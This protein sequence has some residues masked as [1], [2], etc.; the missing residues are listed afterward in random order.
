[1]LHIACSVIIVAIFLRCACSKDNSN[2]VSPWVWKYCD[3]EG[4]E[5]YCRLP[6]TFI[7]DQLH[8]DSI[9]ELLLESGIKKTAIDQAFQL[10]YNDEIDAELD[11]NDSV[12]R[13]ASTIY[14]HFHSRYVITPDGLESVLEKYK[15]HEFGQCPRVYCQGHPVLP[16]GL[17]DTIGSVSVKMFCPCCEEVYHASLPRHRNV[18]G[19]AFGTTLPH[20]LTFLYPEVFMR[21]KPPQSYAPK[22]FGFQFRRPSQHKND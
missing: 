5:L 18:V 19:G 13:L 16:V 3:R 12:N 11:A 10:L 7:C 6:T 1:M 4:H 20:L 22:L 14:H 8:V 21:S 15:K 17:Q 9:Y 2:I